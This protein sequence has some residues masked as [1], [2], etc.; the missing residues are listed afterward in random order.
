MS[1]VVKPRSPQNVHQLERWPYKKMSAK[2]CSPGME[3]CAPQQNCLQNFY[4]LLLTSPRNHTGDLEM[5]LNL[6]LRPQDAQQELAL[7]LNAQKRELEYALTEIGYDM[8]MREGTR[9]EDA[10]I[11]S[12]PTYSGMDNS[13]SIDAATRIISTQVFGA[14]AKYAYPI[15]NL[16][17][18]CRFGSVY[19]TTGGAGSVLLLPHGCPELLKYT[20]PENMKYSISGLKVSEVDKVSIPLS[21]VYRDPTTSV[22]IVT[23]VPKSSFEFGSANPVAQMGGL[24]DEVN[25]TLSYSDFNP[26][27]DMIMDFSSRQYERLRSPSQEDIPGG[28]ILRKM[29]LVM[30]SAILAANP[31]SQTGELLVGYPFS[32]VSTSQS[33]ESMLLKL[34]VYLGSV[35]YR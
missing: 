4:G 32:S 6:F 18:A 15:T 27:Q 5:N 10:I 9:L 7:K 16:M 25:I 13:Q 12:N 17:A 14:L 11:R 19:N 1:L 22:R 29:T 23:H 3:V 20:T 28:F 2:S 24:T 30:S 8:L 35:L 33:T 26:A 21:N 34:R 31:G